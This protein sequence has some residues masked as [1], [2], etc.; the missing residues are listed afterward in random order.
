MPNAMFQLQAPSPVPSQSLSQPATTPSARLR[1]REL[2]R[3]QAQLAAPG[4][5]GYCPGNKK[6]LGGFGPRTAALYVGGVVT[7]TGKGLQGPP[8]PAPAVTLSVTWSL[9]SLLL[10]SPQLQGSRAKKDSLC[11]CLSLSQR[12]WFPKAMP[13]VQDGT[14][15]V[16]VSSTRC[17]PAPPRCSLGQLRMKCSCSCGQAIYPRPPMLNFSAFPSGHL[18]E[19]INVGI[20]ALHS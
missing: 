20:T 2:S 10:H 8:I 11:G 13:R 5:A 18:L 3:K 16:S 9:R 19:W 17:N 6:C 15:D 4:C 1:R 12:L 7:S 14:R